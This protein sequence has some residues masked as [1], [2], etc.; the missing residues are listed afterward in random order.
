MTEETT[1][2]QEATPESQVDD[3]QQTQAAPEQEQEPTS[4]TT[5]WTQ[6][7]AAAEIKALRAEAAKYRKERADA[8]KAQEKADAERLAEQGKYKELYE[9]LQAKAAEFEPLKERYEAVISQIQ[10]TNEKRIAA[11]P[12][13]MRSLVPEY[14]DPLKTAAWLDANSAV[15]HKAPPPP[16]DGRA[17]GQGG[18]AV[19]VSDEEVQA[20]ATRMGIPVEYVDRTTLAKAYKR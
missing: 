19:T 10:E 15:F 5:V 7:S 12:E 18:G 4:P 9:A 14:D 16:L 20:F 17:G 8:I 3:G 11:I 6:E 2:A 13:T 1:L